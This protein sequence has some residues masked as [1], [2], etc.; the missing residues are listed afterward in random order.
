MIRSLSYVL[1]AA[2]TYAPYIFPASGGGKTRS[3]QGI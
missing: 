1:M 2:L 3:P